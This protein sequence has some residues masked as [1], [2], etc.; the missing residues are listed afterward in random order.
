MSAGHA[1]ELTI[2]AVSEDNRTVESSCQVD[3]FRSAQPVAAAAVGA[4][5]TAVHT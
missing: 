1:N 4:F 3:S 5:D 2:E